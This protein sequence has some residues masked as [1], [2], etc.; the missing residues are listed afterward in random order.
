MY[1]NVYRP[2]IARGCQTKYPVMVFIHGG[3]FYE[4]SADSGFY[5]PEYLLDHDVIL[6]NMNYR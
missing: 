5:G 4:G 2:K 6:V 1:L 3:G